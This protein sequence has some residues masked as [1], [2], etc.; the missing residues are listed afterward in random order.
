MQEDLKK[1]LKIQ[2]KDVEILKIEDQKLSFPKQLDESKKQLDEKSKELDS[3]KTTLKE[4]QMNHKKFEIELESKATLRAKYETQLMSVKSNQEYK[5]LEKEI[6]GIKTEVSRLEDE[7]LE[8][9]MGVDAQNAAIKKLEQ[10][11]QEV[12]NQFSQRELEIKNTIKALDECLEQLKAEREVLI[13]DVEPGLFRRY[14]RILNHVHGKAIVP[15]VDRSCQG[16][17]TL[18]TPQVLVDVRRQSELVACDNCAR[19]LFFPEE[20]KTSTNMEHV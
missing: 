2:D 18:L 10:E 6:F 12:K 13:K 3:A 14:S 11:F 20:L 7:I 1:L 8:K 19:L 15:I 9:M 16:C 5:A 4:L 17:H